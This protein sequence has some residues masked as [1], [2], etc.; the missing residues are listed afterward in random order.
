MGS[1]HLLVLCPENVPA[2]SSEILVPIY[3]ITRHRILE[4]RDLN[5][6]RT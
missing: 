1:T 6:A 2:D 4:E 3:K 5:T